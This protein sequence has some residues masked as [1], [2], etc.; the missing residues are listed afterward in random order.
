M[1][2]R[3]A[4]LCVGR[5]AFCFPVH[6]R[7]LGSKSKQ[8]PAS[9]SIRRRSSSSSIKTGH[10]KTDQFLSNSSDDFGAEIRVKNGD[11]IG[12]KIMVV[13]DSSLEAKGA[14]EWALS[15]TVQAQDTI[16][17]L[18]VAQPCKQGETR[19]TLSR[20]LI[21]LLTNIG[22]A[23][24]ESNAKKLN[25]R[26]FELLHSMKKDCQR[27][28]PGVEVEVALLEGKERGAII[29]EEAKKQKVSLLVLGQ[30]RERSMWW[31]LI[32]KCWTS[33]RRTSRSGE[34]V[35][36]CIQNAG[37]MTI[38]VRRK[39]RR[40]GGYLITTKLHKNFWLLA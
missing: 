22:F 15:H 4:R 5:G 23:G 14:L 1:S 19:H 25:L 21:F 3:Y 35:E 24:A 16:V 39:S 27:R 37:C 31:K 11:E 38:A 30:K 12:N 13:V 7:T 6:S 20:F 36:Y 29:V 9:R 26:A 28:R 8:K 18:H 33:R 17:L 32:N 34:V 2:R 10:L 40:L